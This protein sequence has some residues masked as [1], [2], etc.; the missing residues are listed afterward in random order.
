MKSPSAHALE[1][2]LLEEADRVVRFGSQ[3]ALLSLLEMSICLR[4]DI[5]GPLQSLPSAE[6][7]E[8]LRQRIRGI[9]DPRQ[10]LNRCLKEGRRPKPRSKFSKRYLRLRSRSYWQG[11][12][13]ADCIQSA[14]QFENAEAKIRH[15]MHQV[16]GVLLPML[17]A[18]E[19]N[20]RWAGL[21]GVS[22]R[23]RYSILGRSIEVASYYLPRFSVMR[24]HDAA[25]SNPDRAWTP[26]I[27]EADEVL[28][29]ANSKGRRLL[30][31]MDLASPL[32]LL[33]GLN[34]L[35]FELHTE[36]ASSLSLA[37]AG[38]RSE[39]GERVQGADSRDLVMGLSLVSFRHHAECA[40]SSLRTYLEKLAD[41]AT[42]IHSAAPQKWVATKV[43][44]AECQLRTSERRLPLILEDVEGFLASVGSGNSPQ[45]AQWDGVADRINRY[46]EELKSDLVDVMGRLRERADSRLDWHTPRLSIEIELMPPLPNGKDMTVPYKLETVVD[47]STVSAHHGQSD[48]MECRGW[49]AKV[50]SDQRLPW[51]AW[52]CITEIRANVSLSA[53]ISEAEITGRPRPVARS[54]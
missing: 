18:T 31:G 23:G 13:V 51:W 36:L 2:Y 1:L 4:C 20:L 17:R 10:Y 35:S 24:A 39:W 37:N 45:D 11:G 30:N 6:R 9:F 38:Q 41:L 47:W 54:C 22:G 25:A 7:V 48:G 5:H 46:G 53:A 33:V 14:A 19:V 15:A 42:Q 40:M 34:G 12:G 52:P 3:S 44:E 8:H 49:L 50:I 21:A 43:A 26:A 27:L 28:R 29:T 16:F 32:G